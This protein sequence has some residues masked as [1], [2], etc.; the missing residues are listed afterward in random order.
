MDPP[1]NITSNGIDIDFDLLRASDAGG[2]KLIAE[3]KLETPPLSV[4]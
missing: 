1:I 2:S 3:P 4:I